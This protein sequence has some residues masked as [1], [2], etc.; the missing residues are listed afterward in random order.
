MFFFQSFYLDISNFITR[1]IKSVYEI[2]NLNSCS[3]FF[4]PLTKFQYFGFSLFV[5]VVSD[6]SRSHD[7]HFILPRLPFRCNIC[8]KQRAPL[9]LFDTNCFRASLSQHLHLDPR[10]EGTKSPWQVSVHIR[11]PATASCADTTFF[12]SII[13]FSHVHMLSG[14]K[15]MFFAQK[16]QWHLSYLPRISKQDYYYGVLKQI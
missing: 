14:R 15:D 3:I 6:P 2:Y 11:S 4:S 7:Y 13:F 10:R 8:G 5:V 9:T 12:E 16:A 1:K